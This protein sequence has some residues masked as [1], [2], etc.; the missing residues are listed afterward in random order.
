LGAISTLVGVSDERMGEAE[1]LSG[2]VSISPI[3]ALFLQNHK[4]VLCRAWQ[5]NPRRTRPGLLHGDNRQ[6]EDEWLHV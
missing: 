1:T 2:E 5:V 3:D 4:T 6:R